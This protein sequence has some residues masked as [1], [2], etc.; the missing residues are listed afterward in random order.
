MIHPLS[1]VSSVYPL[2]RN[3]SPF[4]RVFVAGL[5]DFPS[6]MKTLKPSDLINPVGKTSFVTVYSLFYP[7]CV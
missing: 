4:R 2:D 3:L 6:E 1:R 5:L 7:L